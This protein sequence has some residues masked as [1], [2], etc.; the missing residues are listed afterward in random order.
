MYSFDIYIRAA[1]EIQRTFR[2]CS[3][4]KQHLR[5]FVTF[6]RFRDSVVKLQRKIKSFLEMKKLKY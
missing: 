1:T 2:G 4:R 5:G 3:S 6:A